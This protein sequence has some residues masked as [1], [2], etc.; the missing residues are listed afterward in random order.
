MFDLESHIANLGESRLP[1]YHN[2]VTRIPGLDPLLGGG[3]SQG[4]AVLVSGT[5]GTGKT[6]LC[7]QL[8]I[9]A[10]EAGEQCVFF[11]V[12][13]SPHGLQEQ[14][15]SF[16]FDIQSVLDS[17]LLQIVYTPLSEI[18]VESVLEGMARKIKEFSP[19][20]FVLDSSSVLLN[21]TDS[22][23]FQRRKIWEV[24]QMAK[25]AGSVVLFTS[26]IP[27]G[28]PSRSSRFG[29]EETMA[30]CVIRLS[31]DL[32]LGCNQRFV[33]VLKHRSHRI[34]QGKWYME[35]E[36]GGIDIFHVENDLQSCGEI[37]DSISFE[38]V[39][40]FVKGRLDYGSSWLC[41]GE[42]GVGKSSVAAQFALEG[43]NRGES[44]IVVTVD[45]P[46][47]QTRDML[48]R[49]GKDVDGWE[50]EG[51]LVL[52]DVFSQTSAEG[53]NWQT[54][55]MNIQR[56][57]NRMPPPIRLVLDSLTP[58]Q[59]VF[60]EQFFE[61]VL[62][63]N[64]LLRHPGVALFDTTTNPG[65]NEDMISLTNFYDVVLSLFTP[66]WGDMQQG[67]NEGMRAMAMTKARGVKVD[68]RPRP[69]VISEQE[70]ILIKG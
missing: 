61:L 68:M 57:L 37:P 39:K 16:G 4:T 55:L 19:S 46:A 44:A 51:R 50:R 15:E 6:T 35:M 65:L 23:A 66:N 32:A 3:F 18:R 14:A 31:M 53:R 21:Q 33:E 49:Q 28:E 10:A 17:G 27:S 9:K 52:L 62:Q 25:V 22:S 1:L 41:L 5:S 42:P 36:A 13:Q 26:D 7:L 63:K 56:H 58:M 48:V 11:S 40:E 38:P 8:L 30:D 54:I 70:G 29:V 60:R 69:Y 64:R 2:L 59:T 47:K 43:L 67:G 24:G 20:Y 12:E 45:G 34:I